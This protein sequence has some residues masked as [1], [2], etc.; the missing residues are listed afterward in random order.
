MSEV[1]FLKAETI[2]VAVE[3]HPPGLLLIKIERDSCRTKILCHIGTVL[4]GY[5]PGAIAY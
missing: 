1:N 5:F 4:T 3:H 2:I